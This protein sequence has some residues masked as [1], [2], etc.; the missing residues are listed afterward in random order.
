[1]ATTPGRLAGANLSQEDSHALHRGGFLHH[2]GMLAI[3]DDVLRKTGPLD[4][5]QFELMKSDMTVGDA[6]SP[7]CD[8]SRGSGRSC[9]II[10]NAAMGPVT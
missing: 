10:M 6:L 9:G 7:T 2:I 5:A 1:M 8:R 4:A 3:P